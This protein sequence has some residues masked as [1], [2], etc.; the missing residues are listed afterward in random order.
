MGF[1]WLLAGDERNSGFFLPCVREFRDSLT[2][3]APLEQHSRICLWHK[4]QPSA[5][6]PVWETPQSSPR[7]LGITRNLGM[8]FSPLWALHLQAVS[9]S[10]SCSGMF[11]GHVQGWCYDT[12]FVPCLRSLPGVPASKPW[13]LAIYSKNERENPLC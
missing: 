2:L 13:V 5:A 1:S 7:N 11:L 8:A 9:L 12:T 3:L 6:N 10:K 4:R